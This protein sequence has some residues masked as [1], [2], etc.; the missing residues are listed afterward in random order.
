M[1]EI[2]VVRME[3][4]RMEEK[5]ENAHYIT[6]NA[7]LSKNMSLSLFLSLRHAQIATRARKG[8]YKSFHSRAIIKTRSGEC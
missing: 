4:L 3:I 6:T 7:G 5:M 1:E 8:V 2:D